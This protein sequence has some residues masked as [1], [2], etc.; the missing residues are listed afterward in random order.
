MAQGTSRS[1]GSAKSRSGSARKSTGGSRSSA[2]ASRRAQSQSRASSS[3]GRTAATRRRTNASRS[4]NGKGAVE[5]VKDTV[6]GGAKSAKDSITNGVQ[7][8][9]DAV[10]TA[11]RKAKGPAL[12]GGAALAGLAGG[13]AIASRAGGPR[14]VLGV[15]V[16]GTRRSLVKINT[17]RRVKARSASKDLLKA[18]GEVGS[19]GRQVGELVTEVRRVRTELDRGRRRSPVEVVLEGLTS[20]RVR[21]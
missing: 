21:G 7:S 4:S 17:P 18:A 12:A 10:T 15:P 13:L 6:G 19:A 20:R 2:A 16:P 11:A 5:S 3:R 14:R 8:T 1:K 9:G